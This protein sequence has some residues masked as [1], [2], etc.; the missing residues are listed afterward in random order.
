V[1]AAPQAMSLV[2][3]APQA[4][5]SRGCS[6]GVGAL[7]NGELSIGLRGERSSCC[8]R[9][10]CGAG[11]HPGIRECG[12][13]SVSHVDV[14][15]SRRN[16]KGEDTL[17]VDRERRLSAKDG[18]RR[19][20]LRPT[21]IKTVTAQSPAIVLC[22]MSHI[23]MLAPGLIVLYIA[24]LHRNETNAVSGRW[25]SVRARAS[26]RTPRQSLLLHQAPPRQSS[27]AQ[28]CT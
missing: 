24:H 10:A 4:R 16:D 9:R 3:R 25:S 18:K 7:D 26:L 6:F 2:E 21:W 14:N 19:N 8:H 23:V 11:A 15:H 5:P 12:D 27:A 17:S 13:S 28:R 20:A 22:R 1:Q